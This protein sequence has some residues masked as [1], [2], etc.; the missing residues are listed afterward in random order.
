[1]TKQP[2]SKWDKRYQGQDLASVQPFAALQANAALL[3]KAGNALDLA[4]GLG[5][6]ALYLAGLGWQVDAIDSSE[7]VISQLVQYAKQHQQNRSR[8]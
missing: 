7:V 2:L 8:G 1:M 4:C 6:N 3:P 5:A